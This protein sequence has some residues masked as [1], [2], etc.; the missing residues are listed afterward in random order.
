MV[1]GVGEVKDNTH[2][3]NL[4]YREGSKTNEKTGGV[5]KSDLSL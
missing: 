1:L 2:F 5:R 3:S 4:D